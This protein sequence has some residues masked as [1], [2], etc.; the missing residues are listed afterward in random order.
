MHYSMEGDVSGIT[1]LTLDS[2]L[3][4]E[5]ASADAKATGDAIRKVSEEVSQNLQ[6]HIQ[7]AENPHNVTKDQVGLGNCDNTSDM[8]KPV[9]TK[10]AEAIEKAKASGDAAQKA[11]GEAKT[12]AQNALP[13][14]GGVMAADIDM[15]S[16]KVTNLAD[17]EADTDAVT[18]KAMETY[19]TNYVSGQLNDSSA[20]KHE[21]YRVDLNSTNWEGTS[22]PYTQAVSVEGILETDKPHYAPIYADDLTVKRLQRKAWSRV[23][24]ADTSD[25]LIT[26]TCFDEKPAFTI[27]V[28]IE[29]NRA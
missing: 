13:K 6:G 18:K 15:G 9:S 12:I 1:P 17:P 27:S 29:V 25:G 22:A 16:H 14:A 10:Q 21:F 26:F 24:D 11:A 23:C 8:D 20:G 2:T 4:L 19:V 28:Q 3:T 5:G 7:G